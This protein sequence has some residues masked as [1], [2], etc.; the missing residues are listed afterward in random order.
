MSLCKAGVPH[1]FPCSR[2]NAFNSLLSIYLYILSHLYPHSGWSSTPIA[3][4]GEFPHMIREVQRL[5]E[6]HVGVSHGRLQLQGLSGPNWPRD[7]I[8]SPVNI[9]IYIYHG[10]ESR[11]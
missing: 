8:I 6:D 3:A 11:K 5:L 9:Y 7:E 2:P 10:I 4:G 1:S